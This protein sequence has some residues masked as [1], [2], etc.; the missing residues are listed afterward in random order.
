MFSIPKKQQDN[1][2]EEEERVE[3]DVKKDEGEGTS[4]EER[5]SK[6]ASEV[7]DAAAEVD[8][9]MAAVTG[10][11]AAEVKEE[12]GEGV[13]GVFSGGDEGG[14]GGEKTGTGLES[15]IGNILEGDKPAK[16]VV[17]DDSIHVMPREYSKAAQRIKSKSGTMMFVVV[18]FFVAT[19]VLLG[20]FYYFKYQERFA[21]EGDD[22]INSKILVE[23][24]FSEEAVKS[25]VDPEVVSFDVEDEPLSFEEEVRARDSQKI[26]DIQEIRTALAGYFFEFKEYPILLEDLVETDHLK[27]VPTNPEVGGERY[28]Y[29]LSVDYDS[30]TLRYNLEE[31]IGLYSAGDQIATEK[32]MSVK[33]RPQD[34]VLEAMGGV[35]DEESDEEIVEEEGDEAVVATT[36]ELVAEEVEQESEV[37]KAERL[38]NMVLD[39]D[40][41]GL[42]DVEEDILGINKALVDSD[43]DGYSDAEELT[44]L[45][46]PMGTGN[47]S[48]NANVVKYTNTIFEYEM[49]RPVSWSPRLVSSGDAIMFRP[50]DSQTIQ[51]L[52][53]DNSLLLPIDEWYAAE[54]S[55]RRI[56]DAQRVSKNGWNGIWSTDGLTIYVAY[57]GSDKVFVISYSPGF[58]AVEN[59]KNIFLMMVNGFELS[60]TVINAIKAEASIASTSA[61]IDLTIATSTSAQEVVVSTTA[62]SIATSTSA[63]DVVASTTA[64]T[65]TTTEE[66]VVEPTGEA[67]IVSVSAKSGVDGSA[68]VSWSSERDYA[69]FLK[70]GTNAELTEADILSSETKAFEEDGYSYTAKIAGLVEDETYYYRVLCSD[71]NDSYE[72][73]IGYVKRTSNDPG[74]INIFNIDAED[75]GGGVIGLSWSA[76]KEYLC[77]TKYYSSDDFGNESVTAMRNSA[78]LEGGVYRYSD[79][80]TVSQEVGSYKFK[81][82]CEKAGGEMNETTYLS[83]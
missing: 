36:T 32:T 73:S 25:K 28:L 38:K 15:A 21:A 27:V 52:A 53:P 34:V 4:V 7:T 35:V 71:A 49:Y 45:N 46:N 76:D 26:A 13:S 78:V 79:S 5:K 3:V 18:L 77:S 81:V 30:Y 37:P 57:S 24:N 72:S 40:L 56:N 29:T 23:E 8:K 33:D 61:S 2:K 60:E 10:E 62:L 14:A 44:T 69:C 51:I 16:K 22:I 6:M 54:V 80:L 67:G 31:D 11:P 41:D 64:E 9:K 58:D 65:A 59:Y 63:Q 42:Y 70:Y 19:G 39:T 82:M 83:L 74:Y 75:K 20:G 48:E 47:I 50:D 12:P 43:G 68:L 66:V 17:F 55:A 1:K